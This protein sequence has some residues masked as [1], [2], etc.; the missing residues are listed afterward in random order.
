MLWGLGFFKGIP[1]NLVFEGVILSYSLI[2]DFIMSSSNSSEDK[3]PVSGPG[4]VPMMSKMTE[5]K[6]TGLNYSD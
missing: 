5:D 1:Y 4:V 2:F 6:L 3:K